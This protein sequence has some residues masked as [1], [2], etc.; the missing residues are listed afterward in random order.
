MIELVEITWD[1]FWDIVNI[2]MKENQKAYVP[3]VSVFLSQGYVNLKVGHPDACFGITL[4][5]K[6]IGFT[7]I[8]LM[9]ANTEPHFYSEASYFI[10]AFII[11]LDYQC[12]GYGFLAFKEVLKFIQTAP[13]GIVESIKLA[14]HK[15]NDQAKHL[16]NK[17]DF[18]QTKLIYPENDMLEI[19][20]NKEI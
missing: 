14:C 11:D 16:Y 6:V 9:P 17:Y 18:I 8:V 10:D 12:N 4:N 15:Q 13:F 7:K 1:N 2:K 20:E 3:S 5:K 19:Y